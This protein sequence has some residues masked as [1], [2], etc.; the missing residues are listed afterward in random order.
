VLQIVHLINHLLNV[1]V[2]RMWKSLF[3]VELCFQPD[4]FISETTLFSGKVNNS[5]FVK[6]E[7]YPKVFI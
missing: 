3:P 2:A 6:P 5:I 4:V 7:K 1:D